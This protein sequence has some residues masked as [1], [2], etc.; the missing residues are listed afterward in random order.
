M[1][2][3][4]LRPAGAWP[5]I[6]ATLAGLLCVLP[7]PAAA[8]EYWEDA[9]THIEADRYAQ[10]LAELDRLLAER[11][12]DSFL[13]RLKGF[14]LIAL[15]RDPQAIPVLEEA[16]TSDP[17]DIAA[18]YYLG[19]A[20]GYSGYIGQAIERLEHVRQAAAGSRYAAASEELL[21]RLYNL[22][23]STGTGYSE[24]RLEASIQAGWKY[25]DNVPARA[26]DDPDSS[27]TDSTSVTLSGYGKYEFLRMDELAVPVR[28]GAE[29]S[30]YQSIHNREVFEAYDLTSATGRLFAYARGDVA[31]KPWTL[32]ADA[33]ATRAWLDEDP[34]SIEYFVGITADLQLNDYVIPSIGYRYT[35]MDFEDDT[36]S[37]EYFS[38]DGR[39]HV[40][41]AGAT[42]YLLD[43]RLILGA[44]YRYTSSDTEGT[45]FQVDSHGVASFI[46]ATLP[47]GFNLTLRGSYSEEDYEEFVPD[48]TRLDDV[49]TLGATVDREFLDGLEVSVSYTTTEADSNRNFAEYDRE[50]VDLAV[51][52][53]F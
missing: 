51:R 36:E 40:A 16:V 28:A 52:Y 29:I 13:L 22:A 49:V 45:Q 26:D 31:E 48:P 2:S 50:V 14:V 23:A 19:Q 30:G 34:Y 27:P 21:E 37:P 42:V 47:A 53:A 25:D 11:P 6:A 15:D 4:V 1:T 12:A 41:S 44:T 3:A 7:P 24:Q 35:D 33:G 10:A 20:Y 39:E 5:W 18:H 46:Y 43:N 8:A 9:V 17:D 38:R 32:N